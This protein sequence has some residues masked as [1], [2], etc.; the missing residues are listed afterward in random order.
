MEDPNS[1][2][3]AETTKVSQG[4]PTKLH[5]SDPNQATDFWKKVQAEGMLPERRSNMAGCIADDGY[6]YIFGG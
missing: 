1:E 5:I 4:R 2:Y 6:L 3:D